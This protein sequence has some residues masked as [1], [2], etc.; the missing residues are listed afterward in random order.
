MIVNI[1]QNIKFDETFL[2]QNLWFVVLIISS[3]LYYKNIF[4]C[5]DFVWYYSYKC[6]N[7][8]EH[9]PIKQNE[10]YLFSLLLL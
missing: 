7:F 2:T 8:I 9:Q 10:L 1:T 3:I 4:N 5:R 6:F